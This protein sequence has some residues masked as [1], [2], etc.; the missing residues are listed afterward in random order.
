[1]F[2]VYV[3]F[4]LFSV[5]EFIILFASDQAS[6]WT[7]LPLLFIVYLMVAN[8]FIYLL[9]LGDTSIDVDFLWKQILWHSEK[10]DFCAV[11]GWAGMPRYWEASAHRKASPPLCSEGLHLAA[12]SWTE[13]SQWHCEKWLHSVE[14]SCLTW[15]GRHVSVKLRL[16]LCFNWLWQLG[17][18]NNV[19]LSYGYF[20][21]LHITNVS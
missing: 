21:N 4:L 15:G 13:P 7:L 14:E 11:P 17:L 12:H 18:N 5:S 19:W 16:C 20:P 8:L 2:F 10:S 3:S 1:M 6:S 9:V